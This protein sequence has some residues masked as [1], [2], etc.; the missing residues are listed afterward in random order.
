M[1]S[2]EKNQKFTGISFDKVSSNRKQIKVSNEYFNW[3]RFRWKI[4]YI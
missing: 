2:L 1:E 3:I 4:I